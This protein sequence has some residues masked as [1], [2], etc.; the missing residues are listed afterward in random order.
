MIN[1]MYLNCEMMYKYYFAI[2]KKIKII[3]HLKYCPM[4]LYI[5]PPV[6]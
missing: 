4:S 6:N 5:I 1:H 2:I 3:S